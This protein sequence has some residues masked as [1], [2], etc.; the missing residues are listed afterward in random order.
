MKTNLSHSKKLKTVKK[1]GAAMQQHA[2]AQFTFL[3]VWKSAIADQMNRLGAAIVR[4]SPPWLRAVG[5]AIRRPFLPIVRRTKKLLGRRPH[6]SFRLT[7]RRDYK[8]SLKLPGYWSFTMIVFRR[9]WKHKK[10]FGL[11]AVLYAFFYALVA[12]FGAQDSYARL[13]DALHA[14]GSD[15]F[16]G[17][18]G[19]VGQAG[20][21]LVTTFTTG[22]NPSPTEVQ[23]VLTTFLSFM[24]WLTMVWLLRNLMAGHNVRLRDGLYSS[25]SPII[26]TFIV[27]LV[28]MIQLLPLALLVLIYNAA[29]LTGLIDNGVEAMLFWTVAILLVVLTLYWMT[30]TIIAMVIV[31]LPGMY[32]FQAIKT[33][34]DLVVG[35]RIRILYRFMWMALI[36]V[37]AWMVIAIPVILFD[38]WLKAVVPAIQWLP[39]V[40]VVVLFMSALTLMWTSSY[41][42]LLYRRIV[43]DDAS[44]A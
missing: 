10:T 33:A 37:I 41:V 3:S 5:R 22:L 18:W 4:I 32:P 30:S 11:L 29:A 1:H 14:V 42:Y 16:T 2:A 8:R 7:R 6:R 19:Q 24:I 43:D 39:L 34:G 17:A 13:T 12:G 36:V 20:L 27:G 40:P 25:G 35:R 26:A 44:P 28:I 31:T 9:L 23:G 21:L 38:S 15:V